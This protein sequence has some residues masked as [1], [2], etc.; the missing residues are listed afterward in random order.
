MSELEVYANQVASHVQATA[1]EQGW[2]R[3]NAYQCG[4]LAKSS[5]LYNSA[6]WGRLEMVNINVDVG[7]MLEGKAHQG[8]IFH[9]YKVA[10]CD[11][12]DTDH[13][14]ICGN[15]LHRDFC[16]RI[17]TLQASAS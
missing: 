1:Q 11:G 7:K 4:Q 9:A 2:S 17:D 14:T 8:H 5:A 13:R 12:T 6:A 3:Q 16:A 15:G 10:A